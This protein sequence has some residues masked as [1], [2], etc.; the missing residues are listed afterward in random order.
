MR[1]E[2]NAFD[3]HIVQVAFH[4]QGRVDAARMRVAAQALLDRYANLRTAFVTDANGDLTQLVLDRVELPWRVADLRG[5]DDAAREEGLERILAEDHY[6]QFDPARPPMLRASLVQLAAETSELVLTVHHALF[7]GW[8]FPLLVR[9]LA[10]LYASEGDASE[11]PRVP[12][13]REF[14]RW[15]SRRDDKAAAAAWAKEM[16]G[17]SE[18][19]L[20]TSETPVDGGEDARVGQ[21]DIPLPLDEA[22][23][24]KKRAAEL[25]VSMGT[26]VQGVWALMLGQLTGK[27]DVIF[28][29]TVSGRPAEVP[30]V[31]Q[32]VGLFVNSLPIRAEYAPSETLG[33]VLKNLQERQTALLDHHHFGLHRIQ[34]EAGLKELFNTIVLF[35]SFPVD[36][37]ALGAANTAAGVSFTG[38]RPPPAPPTRWAWRPTPSRTCA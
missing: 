22:R 16:E 36:K 33:Q 34:R 19:T 29:T 31:D 25:G 23:A 14:L 11:Q 9:D 30:G 24:L 18:P 37:E 20:L 7:D 3:P 4:V 8:S 12:E 2:E 13:Y 6:A 32:M 35:Q 5:L 10:Y 28:G 26:L 21:V 15:L 27:Q 17:V 38:I 1:L